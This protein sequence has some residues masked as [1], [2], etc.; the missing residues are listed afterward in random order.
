M[1]NTKMG[2]KVARIT[3]EA[4]TALLKCPWKGNVRELQ[5]VIERAMILTTGD[6]I[7]LDSLPHDIRSAGAAIPEFR[8]L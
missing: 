8:E 5:N 2:L 3:K 4:Q 7:D 6:A 1:F